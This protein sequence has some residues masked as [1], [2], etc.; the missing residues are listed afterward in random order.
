MATETRTE[1]HDE[2]GIADAGSFNP[3]A[4]VVL[5]DTPAPRVIDKKFMAVMGALGGAESLRFTTRKLVLDHEF[6][7]GAPWVTSVPTNQ[8][9]VAKYAGLYALVCSCPTKSRS[10][11]NGFPATSSSGNSGGCIPQQWER[12]ISTML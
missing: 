4:P 1:L 2:N 3:T 12:S 6:A 11:T 10:R 9:L 5:P 8:H 7:A